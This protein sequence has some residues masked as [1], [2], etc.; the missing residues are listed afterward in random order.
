MTKFAIKS[1][2]KILRMLQSY[3]DIAHEEFHFCLTVNRDSCAAG[4]E[5]SANITFL[6]FA[7]FI[8]EHSSLVPNSTFLFLD[9]SLPPED[10]V[11]A[12]S[13]NFICI[14]I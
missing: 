4:T 10:F 7:A 9:V 8:R 11:A 13:N 5:E 6:Y 12:K 3:L 2:I 1:A 14:F